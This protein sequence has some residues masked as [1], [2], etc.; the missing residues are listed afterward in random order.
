[1]KP[2]R[3]LLISVASLLLLAIG[4]GSAKALQ[5]NLPVWLNSALLGLTLG[6]L[7][8]AL[9]DAW[10]LFKLPAP[11]CQRQLPHT[12][13]LGHTTTVTL[14]FSHAFSR[15]TYI[16]YFDHLPESIQFEQLPYRMLLQP[17]QI[18]STSYPIKPLQRGHF[19]IAGCALRLPSPLGL[20]TAQHFLAQPNNL[21]VYP[22]FSRMQ[23]GQLQANEH[24]LNQLGVQQQQRR[25]TGLEFHQLRDFR[26]DDSIRHIDWK[27]TA[28]KST[29]IIRE[30]QD[31][32]DQQIIFLL[33][34]GR[35]MRSQDGELS[36]LDHALNACLLLAY[37]A[38]RQGDA[39]GVQTF[40]GPQRVIAPRKGQA[41]M[42]VL[43]NALYDI[44]ASQDSADYSAMVKQLLHTQKRRALVIVIS[45]I[46]DEVDSDLLIAMQQLKKHH[47]TLLVSLREDV[48]DTL[49]EQPVRSYQQALL[50]CGGVDYL[51]TRHSNQHKLSAQGI[52]FFDV[53]PS[54][55]STKLLSHYLSIKKSGQY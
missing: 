21:R 15:P 29:P 8:L 44:Q 42:S 24:W 35:N 22:D 33:D 3:A 7:V 26:A 41:Q 14:N 19:T 47:R 52:N 10:R 20:W 46:A 12:V 39:V 5:V 37:A 50:Y 25:G 1:M 4:L 45:N 36:H 27:A 6:L 9:L 34:C 51:Q 38:L 28:R 55:L 2:S 54:Q 13:S 32:R 17:D 11:S 48:L 31:E 16:E 30:Y 53:R 40:A 18:S 43:L 23:S 49:R